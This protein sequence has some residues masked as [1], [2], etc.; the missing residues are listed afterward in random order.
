MQRTKILTS[1]FL[2]T[3][4]LLAG[5]L[6]TAARAVELNCRLLF[7]VYAPAE[8]MK[9]KLETPTM[10]LVDV[11]MEAGTK[12]RRRRRDRDEKKKESRFT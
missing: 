11:C 9:A 8:A 1:N 10:S 2:S 4:I 3:V 7:Q 5:V 12:F 6:L